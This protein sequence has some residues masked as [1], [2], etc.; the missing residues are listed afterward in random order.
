MPMNGAN[1]MLRYA[2]VLAVLSTCVGCDQLTKHIAQSRLKGRPAR[3]LCGGVFRLE[4]AENPGAF[5]GLGRQL[6]AGARQ[7]I[8]VAINLLLAAGLVGAMI[9]RPP[10]AILRLAACSLLLAGAVGN[11][12]DRVRFDGLVIDFMNLGVG[13]L[14]S[15]IFNVAD[16]A[17]S[18]GAVLICL[19]SRRPATPAAPLEPS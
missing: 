15:G 4:Y 12:L 1:R 3:T 16:L 14:R 11:L 17:I 19:S 10:M 8:L 18:T 13:P 5:L 9:V 6:P 2:A 7:G